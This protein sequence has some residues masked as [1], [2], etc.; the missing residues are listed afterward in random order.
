[1]VIARVPFCLV[2]K[3]SSEAVHDAGCFGKDICSTLPSKSHRELSP[4]H[5]MIYS[6]MVRASVP[7]IA[8]QPGA[9]GESSC[10]SLTL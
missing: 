5:R 6:E 4:A 9:L 1:M 2:W 8:T 10:S 7:L 3:D